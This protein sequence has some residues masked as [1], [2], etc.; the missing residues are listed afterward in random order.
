MSENGDSPGGTD[1]LRLK[2]LAEEKYVSGDL[3]SAIKHAKQAH[4]QCPN[5]DGLSEMLTAFKILRTATKPATTTDGAAGPPDYY[6]IFQVERFSNINGIKKQYK[7]LALTLHPD[8]KPFVACEEAFKL[9]GEA[10]RVLSDKIRRKEYDLK[11]RVAMQSSAAEESAAEETFWTACST[12]R[13]LHKFSRQYLGH[14][15]MCPNCKKSFHATEVSEN[16]ENSVPFRD[17]DS[18]GEKNNQVL[19]TRVSARIKAR[20][21]TSVGEVLQREKWRGLKD[22]D[23]AESGSS[24]RVDKSR[25]VGGEEDA[26]N[27]SGGEIEGVRSRRGVQVRGRGED[28]EKSGNNVVQRSRAKRLEVSEEETMTLA[29][30]QM[31]VKKLNKEKLRAKVNEMVTKPNLGEKE[32]ES[33]KEDTEL[34]LSETES[35]IEEAM[36][37]MNVKGK[38][39]RRKVSKGESLE[40]VQRRATKGGDLG[41]KRRKV[42][43]IVDSE[44]MSVEGSDFYEFGNDRE[45]RSFKKGQVWAVYNDDIDDGMPRYYALIDEVLSVNPFEVRLFWL[46]LQNNDDEALINWGKR[47]FHISCGKYKVSEQA[48]V[49][50]LKKF[51]HVMDC[52]RAARA[53][54]RVYPKKGSVWAIYEENNPNADQDVEGKQY[55]IV[56][57]LTS[58]TEIHGLSVAYLEKVD[59]FRTVFKRREIGAHAIRWLGKDEI[60]LMSHQIPAKKLSGEEAVGIS[61]ECWELDPASVPSK[62]LTI[63]QSK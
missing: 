41:A 7:K 38:R 54:Y 53:L 3:K 25:N 29:E 2:T 50:S 34:C 17:I 18:E 6:K 62:M 46:D 45:E 9:V 28:Q 11:L 24:N 48:L 37:T 16:A 44:I 60:T 55:G 63:D 14:N 5:L 21:M 43:I 20:K 13:L 33:E 22:V 1:V 10:Y 27:D 35:E 19:G 40:A 32:L 15:L 30:M 47:G 12:C 57:C 42:S 36:E 4:R 39:E 49:K 52:E 51:S 31:I 56:V 8:K 58:Y 23:E 59:G 26:R 61:K